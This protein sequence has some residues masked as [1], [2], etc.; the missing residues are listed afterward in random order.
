M[1][2]ILFRGAVMAIFSNPKKLGGYM[3]K[4]PPGKCSVEYMDHLKFPFWIVEPEF[5]QFNFYQDAFLAQKQAPNKYSLYEITK[6]YEPETPW[7]DEMGS[8]PHTHHPHER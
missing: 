4:M 2:I 6:E 3:E 5:G 1:Y 8:I 7:K